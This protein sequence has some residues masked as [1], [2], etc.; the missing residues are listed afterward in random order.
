[1]TTNITTN[2]T[3][4]EHFIDLELL[5]PK[6]GLTSMKWARETVRNLITE[7]VVGAD[8]FRQETLPKSLSGQGRPG[9]TYF[10]SLSAAVA[11]ASHARTP[12]AAAWRRAQLGKLLPTPAQPGAIDV[13]ALADAV[14]SKVLARLP[15][16]RN[17]KPMPRAQLTL[18]L[19]PRTSQLNKIVAWLDALPA[20]TEISIDSIADALGIAIDAGMGRRIGRALRDANWALV[21]RLRVTNGQR[22]FYQKT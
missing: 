14:A 2:Q 11:L 4:P 20:G 10:L 3:A 5:A 8:E 18:T 19:D 22:R 15:A 13:E 7:G 16:P 17:R 21:G 1:M 12:E 6:I 9:M